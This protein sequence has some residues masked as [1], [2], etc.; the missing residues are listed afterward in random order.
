MSDDNKLIEVL[1][2]IGRTLAAEQWY[3]SSTYPSTPSDDIN[4]AIAR[5]KAD[6]GRLILDTLKVEFCEFCNEA[7]GQHSWFCRRDR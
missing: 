4:E 1:T 7:N 6:I 5:C 3:S 2:Q